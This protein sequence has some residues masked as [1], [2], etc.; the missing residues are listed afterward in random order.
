MQ[1]ASG[2]RRWMRR[3]DVE[4]D[5]A[6]L[7]LAAHHAAVEIADD[8]GTGGELL[9]QQAARVD[10]EQ[11]RVVAGTLRQDQGIVIADL[12]VPAEP[13]G[14]AEHRGHVAAEAPLLGFRIAG[15]EGVNDGDHAASPIGVGG[16]MPRT[17]AHLQT[18]WR[19]AT[20]AA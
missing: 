2:F 5:L 19:D 10:Q 8:Q 7:A 16:S 13:R 17:L 12:L 18:G 15:G 11:R 20:C 14:D 4:R 6:Q 9:E 3:V 1:V